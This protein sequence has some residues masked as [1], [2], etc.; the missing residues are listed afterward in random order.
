M[1]ALMILK[2]QGLV[3]ETMRKAQRSKFGVCLPWSIP[4]LTG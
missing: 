4:W 1:T 2:M 3:L